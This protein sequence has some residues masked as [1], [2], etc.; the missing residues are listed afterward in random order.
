M[1]QRH[2]FRVE[3]VGPHD[4]YLDILFNRG[5]ETCRQLYD[6][7]V[8]RPSPT[9]LNTDDL[10]M[11]LA[12]EGVRDVLETNVICYSTPMSAHLRQTIHAGGA[13][14]GRELFRFLIETIEPRVL[15]SHGSGTAK[16]L[17]SALNY[18][19]PEPPLQPAEP[20][21]VHV[22][23]LVVILIPSLA[24]PAYNRWCRWA[25]DHLDEVCRRAAKYAA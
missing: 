12:K 8:D 2:G 20:V 18:E 14:K 15:I 23:G 19:M 1:N 16:E 4:R 5:S 3:D 21:E 24:P 11:R 17:G 9:R 25:P 7:L 13:A 10:V 22:A 6:R